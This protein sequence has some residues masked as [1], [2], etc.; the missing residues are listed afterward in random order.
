MGH[1]FK[2]LGRLSAL[3]DDEEF[4]SIFDLSDSS[5]DVSFD[6][7]DSPNKHNPVY[8]EQT[9]SLPLPESPSD[10]NFQAQSPNFIRKMRLDY[11]E[12]FLEIQSEDFVQ[13][14]P[15]DYFSPGLPIS[16]STESI[17]E[18][19]KSEHFSDDEMDEQRES[20]AASSKCEHTTPYRH[21]T[22]FH[23]SIR[24]TFSHVTKSLQKS[25][26]KNHNLM[27][28]SGNIFED[29]S[30]ATCSH[31]GDSSSDSCHQQNWHL[32]LRSTLRHPE[33]VKLFHKHLEGEHSTENLNFYLDCEKLKGFH[34]K[35][36]VKRVVEMYEQYFMDESPMELNLDIK[37]KLEV[38]NN[39]IR[40]PTRK[41]F[42]TPK[43]QV[44]TLMQ[45]DSFP[46]FQSAL[47]KQFSDQI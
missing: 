23:D 44:F 46:R 4:C 13:D 5:I 24:S 29:N 31:L 7:S 27:M 41:C 22:K 43:E 20:R 30:G 16:S 6:A 34:G 35:S 19:Q 32:D 9:S 47:E 36:F 42:D 1:N 17:A 10:S 28:R 18:T 33:G 21:K 14:E 38:A 37:V 11:V 8:I 39:I 40:K 2:R 26:R 15:S 25:V 3:L 45:R 12:R